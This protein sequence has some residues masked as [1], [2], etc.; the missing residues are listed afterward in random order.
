MM[1]VIKER[2]V[3]IMITIVVFAVAF[4]TCKTD[5]EYTN[6]SGNIIN[7]E[8]QRKN[9]IKDRYLRIQTNFQG[10]YFIKNPTI[11]PYSAG[12]VKKEI[13]QGGIYAINLMRFIAGFPDDVELSAEYIDLT[14]HGAILLS[15][16]NQLTHNPSKPADMS[17]MFYQKGKTGASSSNIS[18]VNLPSVTIFRYMDDSDPSNID[19]VGHR[20]W[21]L[22]PPM[23]KTGFGVGTNRYGLMYAF[24]TSRGN[25]D[26]E[27]VT[28]P[29]Q[30]VFPTELANNNLAWSISVN[31]Q[32]YGKPDMNQIKVT[33]KHINSGKVWTFSN[34]TPRSTARQ[35]AYFN[36]DTSGYGVSNCIIFRPALDN[37]FKYQDGDE[38]Q[39]TIS[40]L[41]KD[42]SYTVKMFSINK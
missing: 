32:K 42:I 34:S 3:P 25:V 40:G 33:L 22:N 14:Q 29:S 2:L 10:G 15:A 39:V 1:M 38:F 8:Q 20:R 18:T 37:T 36:V 11:S 24:D 31:A 23:K 21:I 6:V 28:W 5:E 30:G 17:D 4:I 7:N 26:Y 12:E 19:R 13:L 41:E 35:N 9:I 27:Y 16:I